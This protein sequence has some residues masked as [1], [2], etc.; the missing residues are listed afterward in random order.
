VGSGI[1][2]VVMRGLGWKEWEGSMGREGRKSREKYL[3]L[4]RKMSR[5]CS[6][7]QSVE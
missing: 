6:G 4:M 2:E 3:R 5:A 1:N 7:K